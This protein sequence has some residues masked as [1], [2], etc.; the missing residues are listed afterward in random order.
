MKKFLVLV[1]LGLFALSGMQAQSE[2]GGRA[3]QIYLGLNLNSGEYLTGEGNIGFCPIGVYIG[4]TS[5]GSGDGQGITIISGLAEVGYYLFDGFQIGLS[6]YC[7]IY[8]EWDDPDVLLMLGPGVELGY[9]FD[10]GGS[11]ALYV[12]LNAHFNFMSFGSSSD[13]YMGIK[14]MPIV[15]TKI[16]FN[17]SAA[18]DAG[19]FFNYST[20]GREGSS[21]IT[22]TYAGLRLGV[23]LF[24]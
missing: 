21:T 6:V 4:A 3:G 15:G 8:S 18:L 23:N 9:L 19:A 24:L 13:P 12:Q 5:D 2:I 22:N 16:F 1:I 10:L 20:F 14:I 11:V 7:N 17:P